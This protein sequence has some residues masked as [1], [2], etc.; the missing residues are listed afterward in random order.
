[1]SRLI[2]YIRVSSENQIE[3]A[4]LE[5]QRRALRQYAKR[6]GHRLVRIEADEGVSGSKGFEDRPGLA[7]ALDAIKEKRADGLLIYSLHRLARKLDVQEATLAYVWKAEGR[8]FSVDMGEIVK[9]D[10]DEPMRTA[11][12]QVLGAFAQLE[13]SLI[14]A[15][16]RAGRRVKAE[17]GGHAYGRPPYGFRAEGKELIPDEQETKILARMKELRKEG[18]SLRTIAATLESEGLRPRA[19]ERWHAGSLSRLISRLEG[20]PERRRKTNATD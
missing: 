15:R 20:R 9:D 12:R 7:Q 13:K 17:N 16:L 4:G 5:V 10:P 1:M 18:A 19:A 6:A 3:G 8:V 2:G 14:V 11:M